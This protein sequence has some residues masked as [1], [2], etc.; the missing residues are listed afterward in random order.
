MCGGRAL[1]T[2]SL[3]VLVE[4]SKMFPEAQVDFPPFFVTKCAM[5]IT[6]GCWGTTGMVLQQISSVAVSASP[7]HLEPPRTPETPAWGGQ[8]EWRARPCGE[9]RALCCAAAWP[10]AGRW[11][12][13]SPP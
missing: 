9:Q 10:G 8:A 2:L 11:E 4:T 3:V 6:R 13:R 7:A 5:R 12:G 1:P